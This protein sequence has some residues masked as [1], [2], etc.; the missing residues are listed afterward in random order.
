MNFASRWLISFVRNPRVS[1]YTRDTLFGSRF[2]SKKKKPDPRRGRKFNVRYNRI[3]ANTGLK[4]N[5]QTQ[6][7]PLLGKIQSDHLAHNAHPE[8]NVS[9]FRI[10]ASI[11]LVT[12]D[13]VT[14]NI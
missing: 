3:H 1:G 4:S 10:F 5:L 13:I 11:K 9:L 7:E 12:H 8:R 2:A 6:A 14:F